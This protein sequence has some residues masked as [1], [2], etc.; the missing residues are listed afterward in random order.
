MRIR[1]GTWD[2]RIVESVLVMNEY[3]LPPTMEGQ[4]VLDIGA[5]IGSFAVAC[6]RRNAK[7]VVCYEPEPENYILLEANTKETKDERP[8]CHTAIKLVDCAVVGADTSGYVCVRRLTEH[9]FTGGRNTG[10]VDIFGTVP[11]LKDAAVFG[12][13]VKHVLGSFGST[14]IDLMKL[15]CEGAEWGIFANGDF[16]NVN[17][18]VAELHALP[19][20]AHPLLEHFKSMDLSALTEQATRQLQQQ[21]FE[22]NTKQTGPETGK[23]VATRS[24]V[25][26]RTAKPKI[27][28][29]GDAA[30]TSGYGRVTESI[31]SRLVHKGWDVSVLGVSY[32]GDPHNFPYKIYPA[33]DANTGGQRNGVNRIK[34]IIGK[35]QPDVVVIHDDSWNVGIVVDNMAMLNIWAP[36]VG[37]IAIDSENV[38]GDVAVQLRNLKHAVCHTQFG[39]TQLELAGYSGAS[40][41]GHGV[42]CDIYAPY[43]KKQ[44]RE[45][46]ATRQHPDTSECFIWGCVGVN[47]P[48]KRLDL[49]I[50]Y[51]AAWWKKTGKPENAYL[52]L[53]TNWDGVYDLRQIAEYCGIRGRVLGTSSG[54]LPN[55]QMPTLYSAFDA[56]I[57]TS[58]GESWGLTSL[59]SM[60]CGVPNIA[61]RCGGMPSWAGD[62]IK[63][64]EPSVYQFT[65]NR[66]NTKR[67]IA[68][69]DDFTA[70]MSDIYLD[71][72]LR[73]HYSD[74]GMTIA[75]GCKWDSVAA[76][77]DAVLTRVLNVK[78][79][80]TKAATNALA[81]FE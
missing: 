63:W 4:T 25:Q 76:H 27:L 21:G 70:A 17:K 40:V 54:A 48:R 41:A 22:V 60:A 16:S 53:H 39:V 51:F 71:E 28:W 49:T 5:H 43:D 57:S 56:M 65:A 81:E 47:Q 20:V 68:T 37:Y 67:W 80:A 19:E 69:E 64:V 1:P 44:A 2:A 12:I 61:I 77:F 50:A 33:V 26:V 38:R 7:L 78:K 29:V 30:V 79:V 59:E 52:Y 11:E 6:M 34:E 10:H 66:T 15:D 14:K 75:A 18:I 13:N 45:G 32:N 42:D 46:I 74:A 3:G 35:V 23:L 55:D 31:C 58:E 72:D 24:L 36:T 9:D 8:D 62:A 73:K